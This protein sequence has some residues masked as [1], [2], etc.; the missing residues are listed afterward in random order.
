MRGGGRGGEYTII[1]F[2]ILGKTTLI[3]NLHQLEANIVPR[4]FYPTYSPL[5]PDQQILCGFC[6]ILHLPSHL[7]LVFYIDLCYSIDQAL[8]VFK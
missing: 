4:P 2:H 1:R 3:R 7:I 6:F 5:F 8:R